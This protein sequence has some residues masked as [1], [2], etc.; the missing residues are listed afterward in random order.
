[1]YPS[2]RALA[3]DV[4]R[5]VLAELWQD[6]Y[7]DASRSGG[8]PYYSGHTSSWHRGDHNPYLN[9]QMYQTI[10]DSVKNEVLAEVESQQMHRAAQVY[11]LDR[12]LSDRRLQRMVDARYRTIDN[13][14]ADI[15]RELQAF[16]RMETQRSADPYVRQV[17]DVLLEEG[18]RRGIPLEQLIVGLDQKSPM[19]AGMMG[20]VTT[21]LNTGQRKGF[22]YGMGT[23]ILFYL[24]WPSAR[25]NMRSIAVRSVEEG[26]SMV[27]RAKTFIDGN[28]QQPPPAGFVN[29]DPEEPSPGS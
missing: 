5:E 19:G 26:M 9:N 13:M 3:Q 29:F 21:M 4:K 11:G 14:K 6:N 12:S 15:K 25:N 8:Y 20:R 2:D 1:L 16:Q 22:L 23:A 10:K 17:A 27:D 24:L 28:Y 7:T 18:Q